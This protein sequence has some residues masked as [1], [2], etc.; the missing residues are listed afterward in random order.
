MSESDDDMMRPFNQSAPLG[1]TRVNHHFSPQPAKGI[2]NLNPI[3][4]EAVLRN[5][6]E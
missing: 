6:G 1:M 5:E 3:F 2:I 4:E